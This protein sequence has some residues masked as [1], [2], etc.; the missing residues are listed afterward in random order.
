MK[1]IYV[2]YVVCHSIVHLLHE[3]SVHFYNMDKD[4]LS[5]VIPAQMGSSPAIEKA[6]KSIGLPVTL[7]NFH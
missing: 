6:L 4:N 3:A 5:N 1:N 7:E 2:K